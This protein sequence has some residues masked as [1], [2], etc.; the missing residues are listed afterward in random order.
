[1]ILV[2]DNNEP[3]LLG[4]IES[5]DDFVHVSK[6]VDVMNRDLVDSGFDQYQYKAERKGKK[7]YI[8]LL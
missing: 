2:N 5:K 7:A 4:I 1:M 3:D 6:M 8:R